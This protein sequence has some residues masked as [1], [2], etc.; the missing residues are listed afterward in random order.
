MLGGGDALW[1]VSCGI[2]RADDVHRLTQAAFAPYRRLDPPS[3]AVSETVAGVVEAL[4]AGGGAVAEQGGEV[5]GCLRWRLTPDEDLY[6]GRVAVDPSRHGRGIG[7]ALMRWAEAEARRR[8]CRAVAV[9]VR[10]ALPGNLDFFR[11]LGY[12]VTGENRHD[13]YQH[14]TY[15]SLRKD[16]PGVRAVVGGTP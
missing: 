9:A 7:R 5:V 1:I 11:R 16:L 13:G 3:G 10:V 15:L 4:T 12:R 2:E 14:T 8:R 6:V